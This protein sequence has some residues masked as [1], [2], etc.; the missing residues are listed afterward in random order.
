LSLHGALPIYRL[1]AGTVHEHRQA[2]V[3]G[4]GE[5]GIATGAEDRRGAGVRVHAGK[6]LGAQREANLR[7]RQLGHGLQEEGATRSPLRW[8]RAGDE[9]AELE[10]A[11]DGGKERRQG[12]TRAPVLEVVERLQPSLGRDALEEGGGGQVRG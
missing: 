8:R 5:R 9:D 6:I 4:G 2:A 1:A 12:I 3:D 7:V 10:A 11:V